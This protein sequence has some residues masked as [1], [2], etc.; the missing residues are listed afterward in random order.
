L[1]AA[2]ARGVSPPETVEG[3]VRRRDGRETTTGEEPTTSVEGDAANGEK[4]C[5]RGCGGRHTLKAPI[6]RQRR[7][8]LDD[9]KPDV[10]LS[11]TE[12]PTVRAMPFKGPLGDGKSPT[13]LSTGRVDRLNLPPGFPRDVALQSQPFEPHP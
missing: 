11:S 2:A 7:A 12:S 3:T 5:L 6:V 4:V 9:A 1:P 8:N 10:A 13:S